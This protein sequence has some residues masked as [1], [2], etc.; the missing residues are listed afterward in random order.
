[1]L[2]SLYNLVIKNKQKAIS[3]AIIMFIGGLG[4]QVGGVN[5]VDATVKDVVEAAILAV[6]TY[7]GVFFPANK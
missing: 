6:V 7:A 5:L 4:L 2:S 3:G 1:M